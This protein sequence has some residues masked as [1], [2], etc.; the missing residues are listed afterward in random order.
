MQ[1][2]AQMKSVLTPEQS[3]KFQTMR[4]DLNA[5]FKELKDET[6]TDSQK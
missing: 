3:A 4:N 6:V 1:F 2:D 5:S